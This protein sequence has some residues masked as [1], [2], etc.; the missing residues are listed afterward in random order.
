[1]SLQS[2]IDALRRLTHELLYLGLDGEPIYIDRFR[3]LNTAVYRQT[4]LLLPASG[5]SAEEEASLCLA[6]L[7]GYN[8][9]IYNNGDKEEQIQSALT[10][11]WQ[12]LDALSNSLL[13]CQL[14]VACYGE[15]FEEELAQA[16]HAII[17][18]W[19][20]RELT[21]EEREVME[22]LNDLEE[23]PYPWSEV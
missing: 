4:E 3:E 16:A 2:E 14:L 10:R 20:E 9:T 11:S 17:D 21:E 19:G 23:N 12:I 8:A 5:A 1:M 18:S 7:A 15:V 6:L 13:K 22:Q